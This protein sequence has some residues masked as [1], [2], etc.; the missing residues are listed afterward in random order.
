[1]RPGVR[2]RG[3]HATI[4]QADGGMVANCS[5]G[6]LSPTFTGRGEPCLLLMLHLQSAVRRGTQL[7]DDGDGLA[8]VREPRRPR[9]SHDHG[10]ATR[11]TA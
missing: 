2:V 11:D 5:C 3:H 8:G 10:T 4:L 6:Y 1:M 7:T 9:P